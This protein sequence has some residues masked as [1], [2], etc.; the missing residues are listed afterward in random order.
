MPCY[1]DYVKHPYKGH[2]PQMILKLTSPASVSQAIV[3][4]HHMIMLRTS[5]EKMLSIYASEDMTVED[6][7]VM[8]MFLA[9][10]FPQTPNPFRF[11]AGR[12]NAFGNPPSDDPSP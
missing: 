11:F 6:P 10:T 5:F 3:I 7:K 8:V 2:H 1:R 12:M 9:F 4:I